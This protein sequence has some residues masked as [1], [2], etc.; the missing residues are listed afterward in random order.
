MKNNL[1]LK[2]KCLKIVKIPRT[3]EYFFLVLKES[4]KTVLF[5]T[6]PIF[7]H[8]NYYQKVIYMKVV[9]DILFFYFF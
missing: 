7:L 6:F 1:D 3:V 2:S 5:L 8:E 9:T 4:Y